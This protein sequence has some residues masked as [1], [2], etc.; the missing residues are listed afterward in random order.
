MIKVV[1]HGGNLAHLA[2]LA[3]YDPADCIDFSANINPLG[4][5][6]ALKNHLIGEL[7]HL[8][9]YPDVEQGLARDYLATYHGLGRENFLLCNGA[10]EAFYDFARWLQPERAWILEPTFLEYR[11]AFE[12]IGAQI[13]SIPLE[14]PEFTWRFE[15]LCLDLVAVQPGDVVVLCNPNN[16]TG[17]RSARS[18]LEQLITWLGSKGVWCVLD[19]AFIDFVEEGEGASLIPLLQKLEKLVIVRSL[20]K[21]F[22]LPGLRLGYLAMAHVACLEEIR[23]Q[24]PTLDGES[25]GG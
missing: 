13:Q 16:P 23:Q 10:V 7:D 22:A 18:E 12:S 17:T 8:V 3:G 1:E 15:S 9:V 11:K 24:R 6:I 19:E 20:T 21:F 25:F 5:P 14:K 2:A 4:L